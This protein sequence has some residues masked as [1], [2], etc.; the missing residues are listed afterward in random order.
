MCNVC[1]AQFNVINR[2]LHDTTEPFN[3]WDGE[4]LLIFLENKIIER[5]SL[6]CLTEIIASFLNLYNL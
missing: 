6:E 4:E 1:E 2:Y 3:D 5:Y